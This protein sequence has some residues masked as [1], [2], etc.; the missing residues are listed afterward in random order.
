MSSNDRKSTLS[1][2]HS[3]SVLSHEKHTLTEAMKARQKRRLAGPTTCCWTNK[4]ACI[5]EK[6]RVRPPAVRYTQ[7]KKKIYIY[8]HTHTSMHVG[9]YACMRSESESE[10]G[11]QL[12][13]ILRK[14]SKQTCIL[15]CLCLYMCMRSESE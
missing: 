8:I 14:A 11:N 7:E 10:L 3:I 2:K 12:S 5:E 4:A 6:Q 13:G 15:V 9:L 1:L